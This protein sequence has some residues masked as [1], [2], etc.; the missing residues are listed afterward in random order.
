MLDSDRAGGGVENQTSLQTDDVEQVEGPVGYM[1]TASWPLSKESMWS[2]YIWHKAGTC[3]SP[4]VL[5]STK[6]IPDT[7]E[8]YKAHG[9]LKGTA[10]TWGHLDKSSNV[11]REIEN[12]HLYVNIYSSCRQQIKQS[13]SHVWDSILEIHTSQNWWSH[14]GSTN[15]DLDT[16]SSIPE[17]EYRAGTWL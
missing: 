6:Q 5:R 4:D 7:D 10:A 11:S 14:A 17:L 13:M 15:Q 8:K 3:Y 9:S 16:G 2:S 1:T 12:V